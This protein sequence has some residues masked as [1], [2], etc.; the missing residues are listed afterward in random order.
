MVWNAQFWNLD[1]KGG[2]EQ[3]AGPSGSSRMSAPGFTG[4]F[5]L[6]AKRRTVD[7]WEDNDHLPNRPPMTPP[8][9]GRPLPPPGR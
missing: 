5:F 2:K 6:A 1:G 4:P 9:N 8:P 7:Q 3:A